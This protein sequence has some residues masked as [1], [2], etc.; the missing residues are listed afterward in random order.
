MPTVEVK[1]SDFEPPEAVEGG[2]W[3]P[4][5]P[6]TEK[7]YVHV[8]ERSIST[9]SPSSEKVTREEHLRG[10]LHEAVLPAN[11]PDVAELRLTTRVS[12]GKGQ[13]DQT[14][15]VRHLVRPT[16]TGYDL[17]LSNFEMLGKRRDMR[18]APG[19][20]VL[21]SNPVRGVVWDSGKAQLGDLRMATRGQVLGNQ[22]VKAPAGTY[23]DCLVVRYHGVMQGKLETEPGLYAQFPEGRTTRTE[24]HAPGVG[25]VMAKEETRQVVVVGVTRTEVVTKTQTALR[26]TRQASLPASR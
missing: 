23:E 24:W 13:L 25:L 21:P 6:G 16:D 26:G 12:S 8:V 17:L 20:S 11:E 7:L 4:V 10:S 9:E 22:T 2:S 15:T 1:P 18:Y 14:E 19:S 5:Q 3:A